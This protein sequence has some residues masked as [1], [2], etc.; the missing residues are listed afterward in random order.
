MSRFWKKAGDI[1]GVTDTRIED[2]LNVK[3]EDF[4]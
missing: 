2:V 4:N 1:G 3:D